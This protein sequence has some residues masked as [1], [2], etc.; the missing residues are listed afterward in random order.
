MNKIKEKIKKILDKIKWMHYDEYMFIKR[1]LYNFGIFVFCLSIS[2]FIFY[3][4][5][6][7]QIEKND[8]K[9]LQSCENICKGYCKKE[10]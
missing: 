8:Q 1:K 4:V 3:Y 5:T 10:K 6:N 2:L 7:R 9:C